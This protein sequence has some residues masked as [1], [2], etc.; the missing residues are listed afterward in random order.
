M[1]CPYCRGTS[2]TGARF[3][4]ECGAA[5]P[6]CRACGATVSPTHRFCGACGAPLVTG[7]SGVMEATAETVALLPSGA[8]AGAERKPPTL[9]VAAE[10]EH[11][12]RA[13]L[14]VQLPIPPGGEEAA[15]AFYG[16]LLG[17]EE[18]PKPPS[19]R[20]RGG[21]WYRV[22]ALELHL[23][24]EPQFRPA[25]NAR[26][27]FAVDQLLRLREHLERHGVPTRDDPALPDRT[28]FHCE[29][30]F[31]NRLEFAPYEDK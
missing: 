12:V 27:A 28:R 14:H 11:G 26:P 2:P 24:V 30:P 9:V 19:L 31:G 7:P 22:G 16:G 13:L 8:V 21:L 1:L 25:R 20:A 15:R 6:R 23:G 5:L 17:L 10:P 18:I 3:C 4:T 29:D